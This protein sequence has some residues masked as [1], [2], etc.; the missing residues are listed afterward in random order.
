MFFGQTPYRHLG[1][2][3]RFGYLMG[4][5]RIQSGGSTV[6]FSGAAQVVHYD[7]ILTTNSKS[8]AQ[9]FVAFGGGVKVFEGTGVEAAYQ[10]LM[11]YAYL[12]KTRQLEPMASVGAGVKCA[13]A[14][15]LMFRAE[16]RDYITPFPTQVIAPA[17][18]AAF[19]RNILH[20]IVPMVGLS[21]VF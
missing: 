18:N 11:Q 16:V 7:L 21:V 1:G 6:T 9:L 19:G 15:K 2:E 10:P 13:V 4:D 5:L 17:V 3:L 12:T 8:R 14:K 20:D